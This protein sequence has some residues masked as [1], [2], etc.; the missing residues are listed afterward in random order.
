LISRTWLFWSVL[1][2][3][4]TQVAIVAVLVARNAWVDWRLRRLRARSPLLG[5]LFDDMG[6]AGSALLQG[7]LT[8][9]SLLAD[10]RTLEQ[11]LDLV[12]KRGEDPANLSPGE[13]ESSGIV[14]RY[15][16]ALRT[17]KRW[18]RR[19]AAAEMLG[20]TGSPRVVPALLEVALDAVGE[21]PPVRV[22]ALRSLERVR[23]PD[24]APALIEALNSAETWFPPR[25]AAA[26]GRMGSGAVEPLVRE[27]CDHARPA[28]NRRWAAA[29]LGEIGDRRAIRPLHDALADVDPELRARAA[30]A[31]GR[32]RDLSSVGPLLDRLLND[33]SSFVRTAVA[34]ALGSLPARETVEF[35]ARALSDPEWWVRLRAVESLANLGSP[36]RDALLGALHD[37]DPHVAREA[38]RGLDRIGVVTDAIESLRREG[39]TPEVAELLH[40]VGKAG[41]LDALLD[42]LRDP[43]PALVTQLIR[44]LGRVG[45]RRAGPALVDLLSRTEDP[46]LEA[47]V[48]EALCRVRAGGFDAE[49]APYLASA[50]EWVRLACLEYYEA[51]GSPARVP[52]VTGLLADSNPGV[53]RAAL[54]L[55]E[56]MRTPR[57]PVEAV[58]PSLTDPDA[59]V[60]GAAARALAALGRHDLLLAHG[61]ATWD[62]PDFDAL[63]HGLGPGVGLPSVDLAMALLPRAD[64]RDV[65]RLATLVRD[66][67]RSHSDDVLGHLGTR[68]DS[69]ARWARAAAALV[70]PGEAERGDLAR[71]LSDPDER[72]RRT[73]FPAAVYSGAAAEELMPLVAACTTDPSPL[74]A[75]AA[76]RA[77]ALVPGERVGRRIVAALECGDARVAVDVA[78][79]LGLRRALPPKLCEKLAAQAGAQPEVRLALTAACLYQ[80]HEEALPEWL[81]ALRDE[82][83]LR[84]LHRWRDEGHP[85][86]AVLRSQAE[87]P[88]APFLPRLIGA[89]SP[90]FAELMLL[91]ELERSPD[92]ASRLLCVQGLRALESRRAEV[93][94][95][96]V[97]LMDPAPPVRSAAL[98]FLVTRSRLPQKVGILEHALRDPDET[99]AVLAARKSDELLQEEAIPLLLRHLETGRRRFLAAVTD[100]LGKRADEHLDTILRAVAARPESERTLCALARILARTRAVPPPEMVRSLLEHRWA[101]VRAAA[102]AHILPR[103]GVAGAGALFAALVDPS[104]A[105]RHEAVRLLGNPRTDLGERE[106]ERGDA[107]TQARR[108]PSPRVAA[109]AEKAV[110]RIDAEAIAG[111]SATA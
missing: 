41:S 5:S 99:V 6:A 82:E 68:D 97:C 67:A 53:R 9:S 15:L 102:C 20:W 76:V 79:A 110:A 57:L 22:V 12:V 94:L 37:R 59:S 44:V 72:V 43:N 66:V 98:E 55:V 104:P 17:E 64:D 85:L 29:I 62:G 3:A 7:E 96:G 45:D 84:I 81:A 52:D 19:A 88:A 31:L 83:R 90:Y 33:P 56:T 58:L 109:A 24:A 73:A 75:S 30:K 32:L 10:L 48:L 103:L 60:R 42:G 1:T 61:V 78:F 107:L 101:S 8:R 47:R 63:M 13:Y 65:D 23:H 21:P 2:I 54:R 93:V 38:A 51:L 92:A 34:R 95:L 18:V 100:A 4:A 86:L 74:V 49:V 40:D 80:G 105:V 106:D 71:L 28:A 16:R 70:S 77:V 87:Q 69:A 111:R 36:A 27:L 108:D 35:L 89:D 91:H 11:W 14:E 26:L 46:A 39:Y 50:D 25:A